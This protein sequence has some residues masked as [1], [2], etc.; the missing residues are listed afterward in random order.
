MTRLQQHSDFLS[1]LL[2]THPKQQKALIDSANAEQILTLNEILYNTQFNLL[3]FPEEFRKL[4][5]RNR[6]FMKRFIKPKSAKT[7]SRRHYS[8][9]QSSLSRLLAALKPHLKQK[10]TYHGS[11]ENGDTAT[12]EV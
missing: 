1:L 11:Q 12:G 3:D 2:D 7:T 9:H 10:L 6:R 4:V 8:K 5:R